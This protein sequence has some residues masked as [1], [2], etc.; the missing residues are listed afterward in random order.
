MKKI[1]IVTIL[2][3]LIIQV[4]I[5]QI[6]QRDNKIELDLNNTT[7]KDTILHNDS[8]SVFR[9]EIKKS[10]SMVNIQSVIENQLKD[11]EA[12]YELKSTY[13][14]NTVLNANGKFAIQEG[15]TFDSNNYRYLLKNKEWYIAA[16]H[17]SK[18][19]LIYNLS[20]LAKNELY[21]NSMIE[22]DMAQNTF[23]ND[24][25]FNVLRETENIIE[26][27]YLNTIEGKLNS[28]KIVFNKANNK[29]EEVLINAFFKPEENEIAFQSYPT[30]SI[31]N[32]QFISLYFKYT[33]FNSPANTLLFDENKVIRK[34]GNKIGL[35][36]Y[37]NYNVINRM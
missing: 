34:E 8:A 36:T 5:T 28:T 1:I 16:D 6:K 23:K 7:I 31:A 37:K 35:L 14:D 30:D 27:E 17:E 13:P 32:T 10:K 12:L 19:I 26:V 18:N 20:D 24:T 15:R 29:I 25:K 22:G 9:L 4:A 33:Q 3:V 11:F 21:S 2:L